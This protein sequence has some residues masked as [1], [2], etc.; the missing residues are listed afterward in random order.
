MLRDWWQL[1]LDME[2]MLM[3]PMN[4]LDEMVQCA[5]LPAVRRPPPRRKK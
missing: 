1:L 2:T 4:N 5:I 3:R